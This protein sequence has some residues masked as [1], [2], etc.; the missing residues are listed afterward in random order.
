M[1]KNSLF[2]LG[3]ILTT[4]LIYCAF[5]INP[6]CE[7]IA[8]AELPSEYMR[9]FTKAAQELE[10]EIDQVH[11][12]TPKAEVCEINPVFK[13]IS[14]IPAAHYIFVNP[15]WFKTLSEDARLF[16][17]GMNLKYILNPTSYKKIK[18]IAG[19]I[20][21]TIFILALCLSYKFIFLPRDLTR[22]KKII[23][24]LLAGLSMELPLELISDKK[25]IPS[26]IERRE[27]KAIKELT[28]KLNIPLSGAQEFFQAC[29][30]ISEL[31]AQHNSYMK[32]FIDLCQKRLNA[33]EKELNQL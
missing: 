25:I 31:D 33:I 11:I 23:F 29:L 32:P 28:Q 3:L 6:A 16:A 24:S 21:L 1:K 7:Q 5:P 15:D 8:S 10:V 17:A 20:E 30:K 22:T 4:Q 14:I 27:E 19:I 13:W 12:R 26:L 18:H 9:Y 2:T